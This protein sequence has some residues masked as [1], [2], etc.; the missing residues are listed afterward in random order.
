[1]HTWGKAYDPARDG[2]V[3]RIEKYTPLKQPAAGTRH[4][5]AVATTGES[6][7]K[8][9]PRLRVLND[10]KF[11]IWNWVSKERPVGQDKCVDNDTSCAVAGDAGKFEMLGASNYRNLTITTWKSTSGSGY[12]DSPAMD[13]FFVTNAVPA[14]LCGSGAIGA[15]NTTGA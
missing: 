5:F 14:N 6:D 2:T 4:L 15:I 7:D 1:A 10:S 13:S 8:A 9:I 11:E 12:G 3:Y